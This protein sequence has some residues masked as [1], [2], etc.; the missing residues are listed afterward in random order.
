MTV[1]AI[2][3]QLL[4]YS[5]I[6]HLISFC[7]YNIIVFKRS[8]WSLYSPSI[9]SIQVTMNCSLHALKKKKKN[10]RERP[11]IRAMKYSQWYILAA[12]K[13]SLNLDSQK[14]EQQ[15]ASH[16]VHHLYI[17]FY[18]YTP[19][20]SLIFSNL[21]FRSWLLAQSLSRLCACVTVC[22]CSYRKICLLTSMVFENQMLSLSF[23]LNCVRVFIWIR[24]CQCK[25]WLLAK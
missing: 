5:N 7:E 1:H 23:S 8:I 18:S 14:Q 3:G 4:N 12:N 6:G 2:Y 11:K 24:T 19:I 15:L 22:L 9:Y 10:Q 13:N 17:V 16:S 25:M 20:L 21:L